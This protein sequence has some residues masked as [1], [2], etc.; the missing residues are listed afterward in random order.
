MF[1][2]LGFTELILILMIVL[3]IF[4]AGKLPQLGEGL[5]KA[6]KGFKKSVHEAEAI[7]AE[8]Q[9]AAQQT[10]APQVA[11]AAPAQSAPLSQPAGATVQSA[12]R[13]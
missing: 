4:G 2:S 3:I 5:G 7:E 13:A 1:G 6:I 10:A 12:P 8:A 11:T 9:A